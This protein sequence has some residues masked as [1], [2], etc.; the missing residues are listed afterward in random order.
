MRDTNVRK[1]LIESEEASGAFSGEPIEEYIL[2]GHQSYNR[3]LSQ[4]PGGTISP[5]TK[6]RRKR[7]RE[8]SW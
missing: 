3:E 1:K 4:L 5:E 8:S 7:C 6:R 2:V